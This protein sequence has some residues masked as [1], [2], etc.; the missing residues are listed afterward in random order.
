[1]VYGF[2]RIPMLVGCKKTQAQALSSV[3]LIG[4]EFDK[5]QRNIDFFEWE[6]V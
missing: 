6:Q 2:N 5:A 1:M 4:V 3:F